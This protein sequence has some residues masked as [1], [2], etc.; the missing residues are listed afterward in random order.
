ML[1]LFEF[2]CL[3]T[4]QSNPQLIHHLI[5]FD[6]LRIL[7]KE[8]YFSLFHNS[9]LNFLWFNHPW[10]VLCLQSWSYHF[11]FLWPY[12]KSQCW[13]HAKNQSNSL[14]ARSSTGS[15]TWVCVP[16]CRRLYHNSLI[17]CYFIS[18][19]LMFYKLIIKSPLCVI[20]FGIA[21][22]LVWHV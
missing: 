9:L 12:M 4:P 2:G 1:L 6:L 13:L 5:N 3:I 19:W 21:C 14:S 11:Q 18:E 7:S 8:N 15:K 17:V 20:L 22:C 16:L 10:T